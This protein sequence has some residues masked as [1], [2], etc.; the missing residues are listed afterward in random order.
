VRTF[1]A[2]VEIGNFSAAGGALGL[3]QSAVSRQIGALEEALGVRLFERLGRRAVLTSAGV[4]LRA[5]LERLVR[6]AESL[7]RLIADLDTGLRGELRIGASTTPANT[8]VPQLLSAYHRRYPRVTLTFQIAGGGRI[9]ENLERGAI[10]IGFFGAEALPPSVSVV[11]EIADQLIFI[12]APAHPL[13]RKRL[14]PK[15]LESC[16][17]IQRD[18]GSHTRSMVEQWL[19]AQHARPR[20]ILDVG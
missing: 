15:D 3:S 2:L 11:A 16:D 20:T 4:V 5:R 7:P 9:V 13:A 6:E 17:F 10:D 1:L 19:Q 14:T 8:V 18:P 12:A